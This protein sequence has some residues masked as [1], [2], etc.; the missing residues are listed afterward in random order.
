MGGRRAALWLRVST[1]DQ[2]VE[3]QRRD[4]LRLAEMRGFVVVKE[5]DL[6]GISGA[7]GAAQK[8]I[9][10]VI[11]DAGSADGGFD[12]LLIWALDRLSRQGIQATLGMLQ[13]LSNAG[14]GVVS[15]QQPHI[16]TAGPYGELI[17]AI[18][19]TLASME[20]ELISER[21][22]AGLAR[23]KARGQELGRPKGS[24]DKRRRKRR[25]A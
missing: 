13:R 15:H 19:A 21:T 17:V 6:T 9:S 16:D 22:K 4:L 1:S 11:T 25:N 8:Y 14:I 24:K 23:A 10:N 7:R 2:T 3:N 5:Y 12:V 20:R 18:W